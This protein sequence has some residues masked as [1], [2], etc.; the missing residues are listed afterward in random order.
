MKTKKPVAITAV[1]T[2]L[3]V[4]GVVDVVGL[5]GFVRGMVALHVIPPLLSMFIVTFAPVMTLGCAVGMW[6]MRSWSV[7]LYACWATLRNIL[8]FACLGV[9]SLS[10]V[11]VEVLVIVVSFYCIC[12]RRNMLAEPQAPPYDGPTAAVGH[13]E[14]PEG[15]PSVS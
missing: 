10:A 11:S 12:G 13:S 14:V 4:A 8:L 15:P 7:Y 1:C 2:L 5:G 6:K 9:F 3:V